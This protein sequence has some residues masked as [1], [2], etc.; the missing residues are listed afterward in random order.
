MV[1]I[2]FPS[3]SYLPNAAFTCRSLVLILALPQC[4]SYVA[5]RVTFLVPSKL[6]EPEKL[7]KAG[8]DS[9]GTR[10]SPWLA[11]THVNT[12]YL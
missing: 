8:P 3:A 9:E 5:L 12:D 2:P 6:L 1:S 10:S 11:F 4:I 7:L